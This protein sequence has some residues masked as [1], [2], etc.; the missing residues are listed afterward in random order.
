[1]SSEESHE[2]AEMVKEDPLRMMMT[3]EGRSRWYRMAFSFELRALLNQRH[4]VV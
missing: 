3:L 1:M 4:G 2:R